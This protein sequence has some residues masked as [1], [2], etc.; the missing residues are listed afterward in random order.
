[1]S[2]PASS[3]TMGTGHIHPLNKDGVRTL[4]LANLRQETV[5]RNLNCGRQHP[6]MFHITCDLLQGHQGEH[7][8]VLLGGSVLAWPLTP[9]E[10]QQATFDWA[11]GLNQNPY[12]GRTT[13]YR[14]VTPCVR[15]DIEQD[16][17]LRARKAEDQRRGILP[18]LD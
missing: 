17:I 7:E 10:S 8:R 9:R 6:R 4:S 13:P 18:I 11:A 16:R 12:K 15:D 1:M 2:A 5:T 14:R 3:E